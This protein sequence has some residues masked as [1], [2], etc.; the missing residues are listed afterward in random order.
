MA[1][2]TYMITNSTAYSFTNAG[3]SHPQD[4][5]I[6]GTLDIPANGMTSIYST[7]GANVRNTGGLNWT[8]SGADNP[9]LTW[10][11]EAGQ[12]P[13]NMLVDPQVPREANVS[14]EETSRN[15]VGENNVVVNLDISD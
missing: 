10:D 13:Q 15:V 5:T 1:V 3:Q 14:F 9:S 8:A 11:W 4:V 2:I 7:T 12:N 6:S